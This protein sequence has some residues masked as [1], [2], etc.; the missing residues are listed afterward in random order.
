[1]IIDAGRISADLISTDHE[2][3]ELKKDLNATQTAFATFRED[4]R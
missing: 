2:L 4:Y 3:K 1:M